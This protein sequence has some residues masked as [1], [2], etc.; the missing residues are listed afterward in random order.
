VVRSSGPQVQSQATRLRVALGRLS[1]RFRV[2]Y[3]AA[4]DDG[5]SFLELAVLSRLVRMGELT[6]S[7]LAT[8]EQVTTQ[9]VA[10][11][12]RSLENR[13]L[14]IRTGHPSDGRRVVVRLTPGGTEALSGR[15]RSSVAQLADA[16][17]HDFTAKERGQLA[18]AV[19]LLERLAE[20]L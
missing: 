15:E 20:R 8:G 3:T 18:A 13:E 12:L 11:A 16:L 2:L 17:A 9:A 14:V 19:P 7:D 6:P 4:G 10:A 1:R 5:I